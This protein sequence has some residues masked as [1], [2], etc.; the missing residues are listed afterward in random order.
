MTP[1]DAIAALDRQIAAHGQPIAFRRG[2]EAPISVLGF[3]RG[4]K[5]EQLVGMLTQQDRQVVVSP[6]FLDGMLVPVLQTF[7]PWSDGLLWQDTAPWAEEPWVFAP[8]A[9]DDFQTMGRRGKVTSAEPIH[10]GGVL[11]RWNL[12]VRLT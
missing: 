10:L 4:Y 11:V 8:Q 5:P 7:R 6:T 1:A 12:V 2:A 3:V 9:N